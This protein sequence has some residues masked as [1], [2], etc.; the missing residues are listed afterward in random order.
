[1][2]IMIVCGMRLF[3]LVKK[4]NLFLSTF[5]KKYALSVG[6]NLMVEIEILLLHISTNWCLQGFSVLKFFRNMQIKLEL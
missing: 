2:A 5:N 6:I 3:L 4:G 1:M